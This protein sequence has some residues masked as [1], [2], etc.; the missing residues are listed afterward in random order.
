MIIEPNDSQCGAVRD[1]CHG[2]RDTYDYDLR[3]LSIALDEAFK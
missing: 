1:R 3:E 2:T